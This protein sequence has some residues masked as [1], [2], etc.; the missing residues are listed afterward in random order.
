MDEDILEVL[1]RY[2]AML[3]GGRSK[4]I[5]EAAAN[6]IERLRNINYVHV[7]NCEDMVNAPNKTKFFQYFNEWHDFVVEQQRSEQ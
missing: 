1:R 4:Q 2:S 7:W 6:E 5:V 3:N